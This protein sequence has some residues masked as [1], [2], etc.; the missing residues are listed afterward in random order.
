M[1]KYLYT[2]NIFSLRLCGRSLTAK[3][4][5]K[6]GPPEQLIWLSELCPP[7]RSLETVSTD[8]TLHTTSTSQRNC[9]FPP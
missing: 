9:N 3:R 7:K 5:T 6:L 1:S 8:E 2:Y 4:Q